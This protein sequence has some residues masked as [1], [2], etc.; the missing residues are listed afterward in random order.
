M[1]PSINILTAKYAKVNMERICQNTR[2]FPLKSSYI[3]KC[4]N[5]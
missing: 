2:R 3:N 1:T 4:S 5:S